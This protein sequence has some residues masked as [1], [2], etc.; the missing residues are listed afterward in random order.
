MKL[1]GRYSQQ[2]GIFAKSRCR[3]ANVTAETWGFLQLQF[4]DLF[5]NSGSATSSRTRI[6]RVTESGLVVKAARIKCNCTILRFETLE[7]LVRLSNVFGEAVTAGQQCRLPKVAIPRTIGTNDLVNVVCGAD[8]AESFTFQTVRD[9]IDL[10]YDGSS[11][12]FIMIRYRRYTFRTNLE[13]CDPLL[14]SFIQRCDPHPHGPPTTLIDA[15]GTGDENS[16]ILYGSELRDADGCLYRVT[17]MYMTHIVATCF[18][19]CSDNDLIGTEKAFD[20]QLAK[21]LIEKRLNG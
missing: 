1:L 3:L 8:S 19:P 7:H 5:P 15:G 16:N 21:E 14:S 2:Q 11:E 6:H 20:I 17:G 9:G 10:E 4:S 13:G 12:L 18:Y